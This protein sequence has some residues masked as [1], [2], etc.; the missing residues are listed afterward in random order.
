[1]DE[2]S[3][4]EMSELQKAAFLEYQNKEKALAEAQEAYKKQL[5]GELS[6]RR[7]SRQKRLAA[8]GARKG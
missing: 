5:S 6:S 7:S 8:K 4:E 1:M 2:I 3:E